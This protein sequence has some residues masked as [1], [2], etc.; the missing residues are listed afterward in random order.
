MTKKLEELEKTEKTLTKSLERERE[1]TSKLQAHVHSARGEDLRAESESCE[2]GRGDYNTRPADGRAEKA[3]KTCE[4][5]LIFAQ[6]ALDG[7]IGKRREVFEDSERDDKREERGVGL[8]RE[9]W[10][11]R[12]EELTTSVTT[13]C[14]SKSRRKRRR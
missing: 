4:D 1:T 7:L 14:S 10:V 12:V 9:S 13:S 6:D 3:E 5:N 11:K 8:E 2:G